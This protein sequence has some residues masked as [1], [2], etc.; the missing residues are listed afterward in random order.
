M[1]ISN[2]NE[3]NR[4]CTPTMGNLAHEEESNKP[5]PYRQEDSHAT[6]KKNDTLPPGGAA[7]EEP[8]VSYPPFPEITK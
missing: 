7:E 8:P 6:A 3:T 2:Q 4:P 1:N 5:E